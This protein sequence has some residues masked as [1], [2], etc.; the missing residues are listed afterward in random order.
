M[1]TVKTHLQEKNPD[2]VGSFEKGAQDFAK[3]LVG[4]FKDYEF[5]M[6]EIGDDEKYMY[7]LVPNRLCHVH[8]LICNRVVLLNYR[9]DGVTPYVTL[10]K[11]GLSEMKV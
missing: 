11:Q 5:Y 10:W 6:G 7:A 8:A 4:N 3:K 1:K 2:R 9:E